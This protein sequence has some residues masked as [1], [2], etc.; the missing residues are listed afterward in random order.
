[1]VEVNW[2]CGL[3]ESMRTVVLPSL[4]NF[5]TGMKQEPRNQPHRGHATGRWSIGPKN[6]SDRYPQNTKFPDMKQL[7]GVSKRY[8]LFLYEYLDWTEF[9]R[10]RICSCMN[11]WIHSHE[12]AACSIL[13]H[14]W[15]AN[16]HK[17]P[18]KFIKHIQSYKNNNRRTKNSGSHEPNRYNPCESVRPIALKHYIGKFASRWDRYNQPQH[19]SLS[20]QLCQKQHSKYMSPGPIFWW[21]AK[22]WDVNVANAN[23]KD[24]IQKAEREGSKAAKE[25][26][27]MTSTI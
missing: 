11:T 15:A 22:S 20:R 17:L 16:P 4:T 26:Q 2:R 12:D 19:S 5:I 18:K 9:G 25:M 7:D 21:K 8:N 3:Q 10:E 14:T 6:E 1:M 13:P 23:Q 24:I 27:N